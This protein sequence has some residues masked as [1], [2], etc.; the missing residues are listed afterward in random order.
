MT[1]RRRAFALAALLASAATSGGA[2]TADSSLTVMFGAFV[3]TYYAWDTNRPRELDRAYLTQPARHNE[4]NINLAFVEGVLAGDRVR[5]RLAVQFGTS[6]TANYAAEPTIG[7]VSGSDVS[8]N[9][10]EATVGVRL[11]PALWLDGGIFFSHVGNES[12]ISRDNP[13]YTRS[14]TAEFSPYYQSG[15]KLAWQVNPRLAAQL[16]VVNGWQVVSESNGAKSV[17]VRLDYVASPTLTLSA[18][19]LLGREGADSLPHRLRIFHGVSARLT[20]AQRVTLAANVD[21]G[22]QSTENAPASWYG[23]TVIARYQASSAVALAGRIERYADPH[24]VIVNTGTSFGLTANGASLGV[25]VVPAPRTVWRSEIRALTGA[26]AIFPA[27]SGLRRSNVLFV[28]SLALT[29]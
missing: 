18:Y 7:H 28:S 1:P 3:D 10:Q 23:F 27:H 26:D 14:L 15:V 29:L 5:G 9:L 11:A 13:T 17:G 4:F 25:D 12:W 22:R 16:D 24:Q 6:V 2:Q 19:N 21:V 8:R 20:P